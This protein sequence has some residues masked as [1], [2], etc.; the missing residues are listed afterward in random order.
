MIRLIKILIIIAVVILVIGLGS[1]IY[2]YFA[3]QPEKSGEQTSSIPS[4]VVPREELYQSYFSSLSLTKQTFTTKDK[5][6]VNWELKE[7][8]PE[9]TQYVLKLVDKEKA[10]FIS[11]TQP[12]VLKDYDGST[13]PTLPD[14]GE[15]EFWVYLI[16][17]S[18]ESLV[19]TLPFSVE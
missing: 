1:Y 11:E 10:I 15:Y 9:S 2:F 4:N 18:T 13:F 6:L 14:P 19:E 8:I 16:E 12:E 17:D 5:V 7:N 3:C